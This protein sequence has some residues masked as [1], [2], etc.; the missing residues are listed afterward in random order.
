MH[1]ITAKPK[2]VFTKKQRTT[3]QKAIDRSF[4]ELKKGNLLRRKLALK[5]AKADSKLLGQTV[6]ELQTRYEDLF[7]G[8]CTDE[9]L[10]EC[11]HKITAQQRWQLT[12]I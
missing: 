5:C 9:L 11:S 12:E 4:L 1:T 8:I 10:H 3:I 7:S 2:K 6:N